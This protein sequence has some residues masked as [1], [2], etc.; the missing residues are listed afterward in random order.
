[1]RFSKILSAQNHLLKA[2]LISVETDISKGL[3]AFSI[4]GLPNKAVE[5]SRDRVSAAI[6]NSGFKS[7]KQTN[8]KIIVSLAPADLRKEG[9]AF[10]LPIALGYLLAAGDVEF[11]PA[12]KMFAGELALNG[13]VRPVT[14]I[15]S[16]ARLAQKKGLHEIYVPLENAEEAALVSGI[17]VFGIRNL[18]ELLDHVTEKTLLSATPPIS[19]ENY[20]ER[21]RFSG[22]AERRV[23]LDD[24]VGQESAKRGLVI[25]AAGRHNIA[26]VGRPGTGKTMLA[27]ALL[28]IL[29]QPSFEK[30]LESTEIHS[31][32]GCLEGPI[33][34]R[35]PV[36]APHH[37]A[38]YS[39]IVGGGPGPKP[40]EITLAHNGILFMD[41]FAEFDKAVIESLRQPLEDR[42]ISVA[43]ASGSARFP[44]DFILVAAMNPCPCG[45]RN[46]KNR[47]CTCLPA[48]ANAYS[49]R[50]SQPII[51]RIDMWIEMSEVDH[52]KLLSKQTGDRET[53]TA[54][55]LVERA[56]TFHKGLN[57]SENL[58]LSDDAES[59]MHK[60]APKYDL[61]ARGYHR[62]LR[63]A[64]TIANLDQSKIIK[65]PH[66]L[67][68]L[69]Y[70]QRS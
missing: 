55:A 65:A 29:P 58:K 51:D 70:R 54:R 57:D 15:L 44:A 23:L 3:H 61:S 68:A 10:D 56:V 16:F 41:E 27:Q 60:A 62:V 21:Q 12:G 49:K 69:Q 48:T 46:I 64:R 52:T 8:S 38:S 18:R 32:L 28:S 53:D 13:D 39:A 45:N 37:T 40:G 2:H 34:L 24:I 67:E 35:P 19:L 1:M 31:A 9:P 43:R 47:Q 30:I 6:K 14:G 20:A 7:P 59:I 42:V 25:A 66:I 11:D 5:E 17:D 50:I 33:L 36:R 63:L 26:L 4:V 22:K